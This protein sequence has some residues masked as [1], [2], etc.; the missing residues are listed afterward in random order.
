MTFTRSPSSYGQLPRIVC[1]IVN[2]VLI[3]IMASPTNVMTLVHVIPSLS[4]LTVNAVQFRKP[5]NTKVII[6]PFTMLKI[7]RKENAKLVIR[8]T[9]IMSL[10]ALIAISSWESSVLIFHR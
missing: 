5:L 7:L 1:S 3:V 2:F 8:I 10:Y 4:I 9:R 6:I